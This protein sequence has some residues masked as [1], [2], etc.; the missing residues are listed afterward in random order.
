MQRSFSILTRLLRL[1]LVIW[2][3]HHVQQELLRSREEAAADLREQA[4]RKELEA[5]FSVHHNNGYEQGYAKGFAAARSAESLFLKRL[6]I[7]H[8][9]AIKRCKFK[10]MLFRHSLISLIIPLHYVHA[11]GNYR[12][13]CYKKRS[14]LI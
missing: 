5:Q 3:N 4:V 1:H 13:K 2:S 12:R 8:L 10:F 14:L 11:L 9:F 6:I 7:C